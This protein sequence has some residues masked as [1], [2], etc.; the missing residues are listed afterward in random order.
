LSAFGGKAD[1]SDWWPGGVPGGP[2]GYWP[3]GSGCALKASRVITLSSSSAPASLIRS[4]EVCNTSD[5]AARVPFYRR[6]L[7]VAEVP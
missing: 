5:V 3:L 4:L 2:W 1:I 7:N 6:R